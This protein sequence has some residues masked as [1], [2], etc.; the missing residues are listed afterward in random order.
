MIT[1]LLRPFVL[2]T[3]KK[4]EI[5]QKT[6]TQQRIRSESTYLPQTKQPKMETSHEENRCSKIIQ[7]DT[8]CDQQGED[9][10]SIRVQVPKIILHQ[11]H[12]SPASKY[13]SP[14]VYNNSKQHL[15]EDTSRMNFGFP[16]KAMMNDRG[17]RMKVFTL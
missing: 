5:P 9:I 3:T 10:S 15:K 2:T 11:T 13:K 14:K 17:S 12:L 16:S 7:G 6:N 4:M 8:A 1:L